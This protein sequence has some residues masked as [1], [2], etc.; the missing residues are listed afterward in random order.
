[1]LK[2]IL[3]QISIAGIIFVLSLSIIGFF[4]FSAKANDIPPSLDWEAILAT[5][6]ADD[7]GD[8]NGDNNGDDNGDD[9]PPPPP[10]PPSGEIQLEAD[11]FP[12][13]FNPKIRNTTISYV[14]SGNARVDIEMLDSRGRRV[15]MLVNGEAKSAGDHSVDWDGTNTVTSGGEVVGIGAY[16]YRINAKNPSTNQVMATAQGE[17]NV[18]YPTNGAPGTPDGNGTTSPDDNGTIILNNNGPDITSETGPGILL[19]L[20]FPL[21]GL[22]FKKRK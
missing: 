22:I 16:T 15:V 19:Y 18:V 21:G 6:N 17:V 7:N 10:P 2:G 3:K 20:L 11:I 13:T 1:M 5:I 12:K 9:P 4:D 8:N 14:I